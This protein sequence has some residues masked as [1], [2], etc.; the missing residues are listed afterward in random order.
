MDEDLL[1][2]MK[3][4]LPKYAVNC[5]IY[6]GYDNIPVITQMITAEGPQNSLD[7]IENF[8]L[9]HYLND[10]SCYPPTVTENTNLSSDFKPTFVFPPGHR[11]LI[12]SFINDIKGKHMLKCKDTRKRVTN[13]QT[14]S[15]K[16]VKVDQPSSSN[17]FDLEFIFDDVLKRIIK[18]QRKQDCDKILE[19]R[20]HQHYTVNCQLNNSNQL[21]VSVSCERCK[22]RYKLNHKTEPCGNTVVMISNWTSHIKKCIAKAEK[23]TGRGKQVIISKFVK[24]VHNGSIANKDILPKVVANVNTDDISNDTSKE[25]THDLKDDC[26][27]TDTDTS[28]VPNK[29]G[30]GPPEVVANVNTDDSPINISNDASKQITS[31]LKDNCIIT[32]TDTSSVPNKVGSGP[33]GF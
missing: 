3:Q 8:V 31:D 22:S 16:K 26:I 13:D 5:F 6:A 10:K 29:A 1:E 21:D 14:V 23:N 4:T 33:Q 27:I 17:S 9:K 25:I 28:S 24:K 2:S 7:Q 32:D 12:T 19:L 11:V 18:W 30:S 20:E 15:A